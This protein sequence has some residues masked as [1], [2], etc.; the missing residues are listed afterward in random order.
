MF[1]FIFEPLLYF[2]SYPPMQLSVLMFLRVPPT[3]SPG[4]LSHWDTQIFPRSSQHEKWEPALDLNSVTSAGAIA[5]GDDEAPRE[6]CAM[7]KSHPQVQF[8]QKRH[9]IQWPQTLKSFK[10]PFNWLEHWITGQKS[11]FCCLSA[12]HPDEKASWST[13]AEKSTRIRRCELGPSLISQPHYGIPCFRLREI[14]SLDLWVE[15]VFYW[16]RPKGSFRGVQESI[17]SYVTR[18]MSE[19]PFPHL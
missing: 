8:P 6:H 13:R 14:T 2:P 10:S 1:L 16:F 3:Q 7:L 18:E 11:H 5:F 4:V 19:F 9:K 15:T 17:S 12:S